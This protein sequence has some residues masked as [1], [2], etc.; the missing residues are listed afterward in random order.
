MNSSSSITLSKTDSGLITTLLVA[1]Q[2]EFT[3]THGEAINIMKVMTNDTFKKMAEDHRYVSTKA[4]DRIYIKKFLK[5][6]ISGE[7]RLKKMYEVYEV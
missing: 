1:L 4:E 3:R 5:D 6:L 7:E 2:I